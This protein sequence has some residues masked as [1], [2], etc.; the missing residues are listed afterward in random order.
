MAEPKEFKPQY[1]S[2]DGDRRDIVLN[3][4]FL[5][6]LAI[7]AGIALALY[8]CY[9]LSLPFLQALTWAMVLAI[10]LSPAHRWVESHIPRPNLS[11][12]VTVAAS[13]IAAGVP[14]FFIAQQLAREV[15]DGAL[16][17]D[18]A[19]SDFSWRE[20]IGNHVWLAELAA[21]VE[22]RFDAANMLAGI[23]QW[24]AQQTTSFF[25]GSVNQ[26]VGLVLTF[27]MLFY[28]LRDRQGILRALFTFSPLSTAETMLVT[29]RLVEA[30]YASIFGT[31]VIGLVQGTLGGL[32]FWW[33]GLPTPIF[34]GLIMGMLA[35]IPMLGAFVVW[36]PAAAILALEGN[37]A[38]AII[39]ALWGGA[40]IA[41][42]DNL[43]Y[44]I[45]VGNRLRLHTL[46]AFIGTIGGI[47]FFGASGLV[48]G[49]AVIVVTLELMAILK[50]R[51]KT[52]RFELQR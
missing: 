46:A 14:L 42:V 20:R 28:F 9:R 1:S 35:I 37:W 49:P 21:W 24:L 11:A 36:V 40:I 52:D 10:V 48:L 45:L 5:K 43:L 16:H 32:M 44:P 4:S 50:Q 12:S 47:L 33:L 26:V 17:L 3:A 34:W 18:S 8:L 19:L 6:S 39:L 13:V 7:L 22:T 23:A 29:R 27:Y 15:A 31:V 38:S 25:R 2:A 41:T 30:V 51:S